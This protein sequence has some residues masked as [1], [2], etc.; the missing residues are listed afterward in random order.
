MAQK[1]QKHFERSLEKKR[2]S[3][4]LERVIEMARAFCL[5]CP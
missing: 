4:S 2:R 3:N 5:G 1:K